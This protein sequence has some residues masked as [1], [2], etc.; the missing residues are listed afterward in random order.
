MKPKDCTTKET[1][2][3]HLSEYAQHSWVMGNDGRFE[4][5]KPCSYERFVTDF[6]P[7]VEAIE[8]RPELAAAREEGRSLSRDELIDEALDH[9]R[10]GQS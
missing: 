7:W 5:L 6:Y 8:E 4:F 9:V 10:Q 1:K 3:V 2:Y